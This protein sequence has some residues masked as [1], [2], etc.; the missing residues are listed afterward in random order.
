MFRTVNIEMSLKPFKKTDDE[1]IRKVCRNMFEQW[2]P[3]LKNRETVSVMLWTADGSEI[4]D[5]AGN[6]EDEFEWSC[7]IGTA[8]NP[9]ISDEDDPDR[10][11]HER[12]HY[13]SLCKFRY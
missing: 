5:Y 2:R 12:K 10:S 7:Y 8:N 11:L 6:M 9:L 4:L 1:Y 3:L 13:Y